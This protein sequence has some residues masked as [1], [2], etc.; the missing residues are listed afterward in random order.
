[1]RETAEMAGETVS[2]SSVLTFITS[3]LLGSSMQF[4]FGVIRALQLI[5]FQSLLNIN[6]PP[7]MNAFFKV[8]FK[9]SQMDVL[10]GDTLFEVLFTFKE[11][12]PLNEKFDLF[13][14]GDLN[15]IMNSGSIL[16]F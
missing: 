13:G 9:F 12:D 7:V 15:F 11:T 2:Y 8:L 3:L 14:N 5:S 1:V 6:F 10:K 4:L 16:I